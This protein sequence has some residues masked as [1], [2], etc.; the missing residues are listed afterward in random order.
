MASDQIVRVGIIGVGAVGERLLRK[1][2]QHP[3]T[4]VVVLCDTNTERLQ[5]LQEEFGGLH[6]SGNVHEVTQ[7][8][9]IDLV[10]VAVPP[11]GHRDVV[12]EVL[13][14]GKH[15]LCEKP[16][17]NSIEEAEEMVQAVE[18]AGVVH[19]MNFPTTYGNV[20]RSLQE[21]FQK[22]DIGVLQRINVK[23]HF[24]EWPR[25]WQRNAWIGSREQ[26]GFVR[27]VGPH[28]IQLIQ[29]LFGE[30]VN[31]QTYIEFPD[32]PELCETG[33]IARM[34]LANGVPILVDGVS[35]VG[36]KEDIS[37]T[38][39]GDKGTLTLANWSELRIGTTEG[40]QAIPME[41][42]DHLHALLTEVVK[43]VKGEPASLVTLHDGLEVQK[44]LEQL[45]DRG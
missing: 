14:A 33:I 37:F 41:R 36:K 28:Y 20:F 30:I 5:A 4:E 12:S 39:Y 31:V 40:E 44:V 29:R 45:L 15:L 32:D 10:Y 18:Q 21:S 1:F 42:D 27:E 38:L 13:R 17:A 8:P 24:P 23:M 22:G 9:D 19:A 2:V 7:N 34:E 25:A 35:G 3:Q 11:K 16:L 6:I 26:G 43:A